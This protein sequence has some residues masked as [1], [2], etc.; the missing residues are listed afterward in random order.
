ME[1]VFVLLAVVLLVILPVALFLL[2]V[3]SLIYTVVK[4]IRGEKAGDV[5]TSPARSRDA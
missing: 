1:L 2:A 5:V 3:G 4:A